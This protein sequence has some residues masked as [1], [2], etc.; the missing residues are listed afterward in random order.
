MKT[1]LQR[2]LQ[3]KGWDFCCEMAILYPG[4]KILVVCPV[5]SQS[6]QFIKKIYE[7]MRMS[8]NLEQEI[9]VDEIKTSVNDSKIPFKNGS[10][11][12]AATYSENALGII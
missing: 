2:H 12:F 5:K 10:I 8:K 9:V 3:N 4:I 7:Y 1:L 11:I 6:T